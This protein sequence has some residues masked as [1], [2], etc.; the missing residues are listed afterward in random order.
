MPKQPLRTKD[1]LTIGIFTTIYAFIM[2][3]AGVASAPAPYLLFI[4]MSIAAFAN[5]TVYMLY[6]TKV[7]RWGMVLMLGIL[8]GLIMIAV[9]KSWTVL[10]TVLISGLL[11]E[12]ILYAGRYTAPWAQVLSYSVFTLWFIGPLLPLLWFPAE[13]RASVAE[14]SGQDYAD[15]F[16]SFFTLPVVVGFGLLM[17][18][19]ACSGALVGRVI[20]K[21]HFSSQSLASR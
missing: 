14:G 15:A 20:V 9:G 19:M 1:L 13:Y 10:F 5:G 12:A 8:M 21:K 7:R 16:L 4:F 17:A 18:V 2:A 6:L 3:V 11:A